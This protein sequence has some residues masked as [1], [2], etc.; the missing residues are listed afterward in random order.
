[1]GARAP[2]VSEA[3]RALQA[4]GKAQQAGRVWFLRSVPAAPPVAR[5][6]R[7]KWRPRGRR[8]PYRQPLNRG[9]CTYSGRILE[10]VR[11]PL[12]VP[13]LYGRRRRT[14]EVV[15]PFRSA[16]TCRGTVERNGELRASSVRSHQ[17]SKVDS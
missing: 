13:E 12:D 5:A 4:D 2:A 11:T 9:E 7:N 16:H 15:F 14:V 8:R 17:L 6:E 1:M 10:T 3:L